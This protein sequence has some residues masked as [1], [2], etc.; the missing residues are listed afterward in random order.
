[1]PKLTMNRRD[2]ALLLATSGPTSALL[3]GLAGCGK[4]EAPSPAASGPGGVPSAP[5]AG[6]DY[7]VLKKPAAT[8]TPKGKAELIEFFGY[9]CPHCNTL[10]PAMEA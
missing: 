2:F 6:I 9:W 7:R 8:E 4:K 5:V 1:M 3:A 10:A